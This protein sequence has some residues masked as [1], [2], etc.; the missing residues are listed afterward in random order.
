MCVNQNEHQEEPNGE[1]REC[2]W[3]FFVWIY[4]CDF[5]LFMIIKGT[6][7]FDKRLINFFRDA[8]EKSVVKVWMI[9]NVI[10]CWNCFYKKY[11]FFVRFFMLKNIFMLTG[12]LCFC[13]CDLRD[14]FLKAD[15]WLK[16]V[17][18]VLIE[19]FEYMIL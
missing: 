14:V 5:I 6:G 7:F 2:K 19:S 18:K 10:L 1:T 8:K 13:K 15:M 4:V 16:D 3:F 11:D 9:L 12:S 17:K